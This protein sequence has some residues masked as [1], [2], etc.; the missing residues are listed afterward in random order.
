LF[1]EDY[2]YNMEVMDFGVA[3]SGSGAYLG[4]RY[5]RKNW[6]VE[7]RLQN[8]TFGYILHGNNPF[9]GLGGFVWLV[10]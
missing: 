8:D 3:N 2:Y 5:E 1:A 10:L 6:A 7:T 9:I 4:L